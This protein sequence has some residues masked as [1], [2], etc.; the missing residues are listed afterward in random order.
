MLCS[1]FAGIFHIL[2]TEEDVA[3]TALLALE[4]QSEEVPRAGSSKA[5]QKQL[6][7]KLATEEVQALR[8]DL[9]DFVA[10]LGLGLTTSTAQAERSEKKKTKKAVSKGC[11]QLES[12]MQDLFMLEDIQDQPKTA[13]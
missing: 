11:H 6:N 1:K 5:P 8:H 3:R 9:T 2:D 7:A 13:D 12:S 4:V 10:R